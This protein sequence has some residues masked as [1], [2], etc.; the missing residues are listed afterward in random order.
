[1]TFIFFFSQNQKGMTEVAFWKSCNTITVLILSQVP[2]K[3]TGFHVSSI[4]SIYPVICCMVP[5]TSQ[6]LSLVVPNY[7]F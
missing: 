4:Q 2:E 5:D 7:P 3:I 6:L 1:M